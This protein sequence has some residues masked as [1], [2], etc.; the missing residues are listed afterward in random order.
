M[1]DLDDPEHWLAIVEELRAEIAQRDERLR[2]VLGHVVE[3]RAEN[4]RLRAALQSIANYPHNAPDLIRAVAQIEVDRTA[5][6][7]TKP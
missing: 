7:D 2:A 3:L 6:K 1:T 5:L 4:A